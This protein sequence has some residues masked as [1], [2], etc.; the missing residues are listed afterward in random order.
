[1]GCVVPVFVSVFGETAVPNSS[2]PE[3]P[4]QTKSQL[5]LL[6]A[7]DT[8]RNLASISWP[9]PNVFYSI[10]P[11]LFRLQ[12]VSDNYLPNWKMLQAKQI[13]FLSRKLSVN[14]LFVT[15][16]H[17]GFFCPLGTLDILLQDLV[18]SINVSGRC[19]LTNYKFKH[20]R[21]LGC[22]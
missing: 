9:G 15:C 20:F 8:V 4:T 21:S 1:M 10:T 7:R 2:F 13:S 5:S 18:S 12:E 19:H 22:L 6:E 14:T 16:E 11:P 17:S 3:T